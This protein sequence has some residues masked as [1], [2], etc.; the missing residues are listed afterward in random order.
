MTA[1]LLTFWKLKWSLLRLGLAAILLWGAV[2]DNPF[3]LARLQ[4]ARLPQ[5]DYLTEARTLAKQSRFA[6]ALVVADAGLEELEGEQRDSLATER[7]RIAAERDSLVR[8]GSELLRGAVIGEGRSTEAL[9][10]AVTADF[11]LV[12]D[13]RDLFIQG[14]KRIA[15]GEADDLILALSAVGVLT[16]V[17][18]EIDWIAAFLKIAKKTGSLTVKMGEA[19]LRIIR[20]ATSTK[21]F[22][23]LR[24][25]FGHVQAVAEHATP[26]G[27]LRIFRHVDDPKQLERVADF[28][29]SEK[30]GGF[31]L[32]VTKKEGIDALQAAGKEADNALVLA[33]KRGDRGIAWFR[34]GGYRLLRPHPL[35]GLFKGLRKGTL[36]RAI[37]RALSEY[38]DPFGWF[39]I[40][41][42]ALW[43]FG[44]LWLLVRRLPTLRRSG[45]PS[46]AA[47][48]G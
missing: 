48:A 6:E 9:I 4:Y 13:L 43:F 32:H 23:E 27:A 14:S 8:R 10:G 40:P 28:V 42:F 36:T 41:A 2:A 45:A 39:V 16:T 3:R 38:V 17:M 7:D 37:E 22:T 33:A 30:A 35:I 11:F 44:E 26:A 1:A 19:L 18:P 21:D 29:K 5:F 47:V 25:V 46:T 12:G 31:A 15:D 24:K 34:T 20:R